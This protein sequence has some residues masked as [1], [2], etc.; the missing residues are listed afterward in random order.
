M[1]VICTLPHA[2]DEINGIKFEDHKEGKVSAEAVPADVAERFAR[3]EG[4]KVVESKGVKKAAHKEADATE[5]APEVVAADKAGAD[6]VEE[7]PAKASS[8]K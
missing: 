3:I 2:S 6:S 5:A 8:K 7:K 1:F 4:Y